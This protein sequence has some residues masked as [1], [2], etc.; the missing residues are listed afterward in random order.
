MALPSELVDS[1]IQKLEVS[2]HEELGVN[3]V[4]KEPKIDI[5]G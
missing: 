3:V 1:I 2:R 5:L 4:V